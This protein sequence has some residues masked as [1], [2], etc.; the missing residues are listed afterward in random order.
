[1]PGKFV[2]HTF[3]QILTGDPFYYSYQYKSAL[4]EP[5]QEMAQAAT[6]SRMLDHNRDHNI[7]LVPPE[8]RKHSLVLKADF[9]ALEQRKAIAAEKW[10][11]AQSWQY[12]HEQNMVEKRAEWEMQR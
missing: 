3:Q 9:P 10:K 4:R 8:H 2:D 6:V 11:E 1:M 12:Q 5:N 7:E